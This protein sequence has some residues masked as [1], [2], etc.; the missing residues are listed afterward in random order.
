MCQKYD[1]NSLLHYILS[2]ISFLYF[3]VLFLTQDIFGSKYYTVCN[4]F[5]SI[6]ALKIKRRMLNKEKQFR[7]EY[8]NKSLI[9]N[10]GLKYHECTHTGKRPYSCSLCHKVFAKKCSLK[11]HKEIHTGIKA[12]K[13]NSCDKTFA[14][15]KQLSNHTR[16]HTGQKSRECSLCHKVFSGRSSLM[17]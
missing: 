4:D 2:L 3:P 17:I 7:C 15:K 10:D 13:C 14:K 9:H 1:I 12:Y 6:K 8:C 11:Y 5:Y 16:A